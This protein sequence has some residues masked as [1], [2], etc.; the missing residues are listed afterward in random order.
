MCP[1][2]ELNIPVKEI[3]TNIAFKKFQT[4]LHICIR[5][6]EIGEHSTLIV[7]RSLDLPVDASPL[8]GEDAR[9]GVHEVGD[10]LAA[11]V[12]HDALVVVTLVP[13]ARERG[14]VF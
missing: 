10:D 7:A 2:I 3:L 12:S 5:Q 14:W 13:V 6:S 1:L 4:L 8:D 11:G 9:P